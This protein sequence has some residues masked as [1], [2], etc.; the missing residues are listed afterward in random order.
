MTQTATIGHN[1]PPIDDEA[2]LHME[3]AARQA[4]ILEGTGKLLASAGRAPTECKSEEDA[5]D[6]TTLIKLI[7]DNAKSLE[8][9]RENEK[10][11]YWNAGKIVDSFFKSHIGDL[12]TAKNNVNK[13]LSAW[14]TKKA[15]EERRA[16]EE[17]ARLERERAARELEAAA[18][19]EKAGHNEFAESAL[20]QAAITEQNAT[21]LATSAQAKPAHLA[22]T[23]SVSGTASLRT[24]WVGD[25]TDRATLDLEALRPYL[26][27]DAMQA[28][29]NAFIRSGGRELK[30]A[31]IYETSSAV[32]R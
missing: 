23:R 10:A 32:V 26:T 22:T 24:I 14:L 25:V 5:K 2:T 1:K 7:N 29:V 9:A 30:G 15:D 17:T 31:R 3:L 4:K 8:A 27:A 18:A 28:A 16:R 19:M 11:P 13:P 12:T 20:S 6:I 21:K